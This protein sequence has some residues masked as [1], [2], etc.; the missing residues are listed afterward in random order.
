[1]FFLNKESNT[2]QDE[3]FKN[4]L[5]NKCCNLPCYKTRSCIKY[6]NSKCFDNKLLYP[7]SNLT[8]TNKV[9]MEGNCFYFFKNYYLYLC[10]FSK[11]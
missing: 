6:Y 8:K 2:N 3:I 1:M 7:Y 9:C 5:D 10:F 11:F 4:N